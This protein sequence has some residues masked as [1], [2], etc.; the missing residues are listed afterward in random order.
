ME[1]VEAEADARSLFHSERG[2]IGN[3]ELYGIHPG[4]YWDK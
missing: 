1:A 2:S 4:T 3:V